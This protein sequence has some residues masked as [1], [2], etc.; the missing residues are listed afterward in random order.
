MRSRKIMK[1][2]LCFTDSLGSG[3][4]QRQLVGLAIMLKERGYNVSVVLY[5]DIPFYTDVL[6]RN[7]IQIEIIKTGSNPIK[8]ILKFRKYFKSKNAN[9][10]IAYQETPSLVAAVCR[11]FGCNYR[12]I[13]SERNTTQSMGVNERVR[14]FLYR[15]AD[16][17]VPNSYSQSNFL[18]NNYPWM[19]SKIKTITN[20]VDFSEFY[21]VKRSCSKV[22]KILVVASA[23][24]SKNLHG[25]IEACRILK[26]RNVKFTTE[27][28][29]LTDVITQ[30]QSKA[31]EL[32][33]NYYL[34][35]IFKLLPKSI[36]IAN[37]YREADYF[38]LPSFYEGTPNVLCEAIAMGLPVACSYVCDNPIYVENGVNGYLFNPNDSDDMANKIQ[39]L[40]LLDNEK[41]QFYCENSEKIAHDKL[42]KETFL[43]KYLEI[44]LV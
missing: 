43:N 2:I 5:H 18:E 6:I 39:K 37:K 7:N 3:G 17:I 19:K 40:I 10:V 44:L 25:Y 8:R 36:N 14:F 38:C 28:Y 11:L 22:P 9:W 35:D 27:W 41:Y 12:L 20:F 1:K 21:S 16:F 32:I 31:F 29:G 30:Y 34:G 23:S 33:K 4:A 42:E 26:E 15:F 13:V 24:Q